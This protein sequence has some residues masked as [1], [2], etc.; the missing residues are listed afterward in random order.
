LVFAWHNH[1]RELR[2]L[3][4]GSFPI[5]DL[6]G[7]HLAWEID[8]GWTVVAGADPLDWLRE[9]RG[10]I[11]ALHI[12]DVPVPG[13]P[14]D[15]GGQ[16]ALGDGTLGWATLWPACVDSG[17]ELMVAEHDFT[18]DYETFARRSL[19]FMQRLRDG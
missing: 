14:N 16:T 17:S 6:L 13:A 19:V 10:R 9:Y 15:E 18:A 5:R 7:E 1:D 11:P 3:P 8:L 4:D 12:K 2:A